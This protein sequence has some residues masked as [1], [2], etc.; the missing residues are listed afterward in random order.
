MSSLK[1]LVSNIKKQ[2]LILIIILIV[3][4]IIRLTLLD[5]R[6]PHHDEGVNGW[7]ADQVKQNGFYRYDPTNY[8]GPLTFYILFFFQT[9]FG[10]N[11]WALRLPTVIISLITIYVI[12]LFARFIGRKASLIAALAFALS[13]ANIYFS[14][15]VNIDATLVLFQIISAWGIIGLLSEGSKKYLWALGLGITGMVLTKETYIIH[16]ASFIIAIVTLN[17]LEKFHSSSNKE[18]LKTT[19]TWT[20]NELQI[21]II[22]CLAII[23]LFYSGGFLNIKGIFGLYETYL[24]WFNTSKSGVHAKS[25]FYWIEIMFKYEQIGLIGLIAIIRYIYPGKRWLRY[26]AIYGLGMFFIYSLVPYKTP[27]LIVNILWPFYFTFGGIISELLN[28]T[29]KKFVILASG[30]LFA[31]SGILGIDISFINY[32][33]HKVP[34]VY[35]QTF[36]DIKKLTE[37]INNLVKEDPAQEYKLTG[38]ILRTDEWPLPWTLSNLTMVGYFA[39]GNAPSSYDADFLF[40]ESQRVNEVEEN[41]QKE[42]FTDIFQLRDSQDPS[43]LYL[44]YEKFKNMFPGRIAEFKPLPKEPI[45]PGTGLLA[46]FYPNEKWVG[47]PVM[48]QNVR[49]INFYWEGE[50]RILPAPFSAEFTGEI[51]LQPN[52]ILVLSVDDGG[53]LEI[54][55]ERVINDPGP[56]AVQSSRVMVNKPGWKKIKVGFYDIAGGA[57]VR[58]SKLSANNTE[59]PID[60]NDLRYNTRLL[61]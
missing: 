23:I 32:L 12:S 38:N 6:P 10:H 36:N 40:V 19:Q 21:V 34:Y 44:S 35:V 56:H 14:R 50:H 15:F 28:S 33:N 4:A 60:I 17:F 16:I 3:A 55:G 5:L 8:H 61:K 2:D 42:Y 11:I 52:T 20:K 24:T 26:F 29:W 9:L 30:I 18:T 39:P 27:W 22:T 49:N 54:D 48:K 43:K 13:P 46:H 41:L 31:I 53:F 25:Y 58:L 1:T 7:F 37:P 47:P 45:V 57:I 51:N 59:V